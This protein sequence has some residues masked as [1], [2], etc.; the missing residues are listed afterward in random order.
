MKPQTVFMHIA[1][2][3]IFA[4]LGNNSGGISAATSIQQ[5]PGRGPV[6]QPRDPELEK[7]SYHNLDVAKYYFYKRKPDKKDKD[8]WTRLNKAVEGRL[9]EIIDLN[10]DFAKMDEV[11]FL[12][13]EVYQRG[14]DRENAVKHWTMVVE[15][16]P[17]STV[18]ADAQKRLDEAQNQSKDKKG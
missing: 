8:G 4:A 1:A 15:K 16:F 10:P 9:M 17:D 5:G 13:G 12:L 18:K 3:V 2:A 14:G 11:Y 7:Q 6:S